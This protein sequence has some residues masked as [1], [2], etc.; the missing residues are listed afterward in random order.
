LATQA[1]LFATLLAFARAHQDGDRFFGALAGTLV[2]LILFTRI[3]ALPVIAGL[4][5]AGSLAWL[6]EG[7]AIQSGFV[8]SL[9]P[10]IAAA[11]MYYTGPILPYTK[12]LFLFLHNLPVSG[13]S[14]VAIS[15]AV[16]FVALLALR[17]R[18]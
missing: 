11:W 12:R 16:V 7:R 1:L 6:V 15:L 5:A 9:V 10:W 2:G 14:T 4:L 17:A 13:V 8:V 18:F 3:D